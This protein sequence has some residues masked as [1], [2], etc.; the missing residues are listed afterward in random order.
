M[1]RRLA[2]ILAADVAAYSRLMHENEEATHVRFIEVLSGVVEPAIAQHGGR[3]VKSTGDG[4]LAEFGSAVDAVGCAMQF[5]D[6]IAAINADAAD[7]SPLEFRVGIHVGEVIVEHRDIYGD[8]VNIA[9][10]VNGVA[11]AGGITVSEAVHENVRG[12]L[13]CD[14]EDLGAQQVKNIARPLRLFRVLSARRRS[15]PAPRRPVAPARP[16]IAVLAFQNLS[17]DPE[18]DNFADGIVEDVATALSRFRALFV[19]ARKSTSTHQQRGVDARQVGRELGARYVVEGSLRKVGS[20]LRISVQAVQ[21]DTG[22]HLWAE[23]Y[24]RDLIDIFAA[25]DE[26]TASIVGALVPALERAEIERARRKPA[27][28]LDACDLYLRALAAHRDPTRKGNEEARALVRQALALDPHFVPALVLADASVASGV[29]NGWLPREALASALGHAR[30][31]VELAPEDAE[32]LAALA[33]RA[34]SVA[35]DAEQAVALAGRAIAANPLSASVWRRS[36]YAC[37]YA[38]RPEQALSMFERARQLGSDD[39]LTWSGSG[40]ALLCLERDGEAIEAARRAAGHNPASTDAGRI[41]AAGLALAGRGDEAAAAL[42]GLLDLDASCSIETVRRRFGMTGTG[43]ARLF[44]GLRRAGLAEASAAPVRSGG[45]AA[46]GNAGVAR[47]LREPRRTLLVSQ[48]DVPLREIAIGAAPLLVGRAADAGLVLSDHR[49]SRAHC[50]IV[51][52]DDQVTAT[53][54]NSTNGTLLDGRPITRTTVLRPGAVLEIGSCRL[55]YCC[56]AAADP[57]ATIAGSAPESLFGLTAAAGTC[58]LNGE[59]GSRAVM[60]YKGYISGRIDTW[61]W[62]TISPS[63]PSRVCLRPKE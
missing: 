31:A 4:F 34:A 39:D 56:E 60:E 22:A 52:A 3:I 25:Q 62:T 9:V 50:R 40:Y 63:A 59:R 29:A 47:A 5:Q 14:F 33:L 2:A 51:L 53:D 13:S 48:P 6:D 18:Q 42:R 20:R 38:G 55:E 26:T 27:H 30:L 17:G 8:G 57:D 28:D 37:L 7:E 43:G 44:E 21:T 46:T 12:R 49:V 54:L 19:I 11:D 23:R 58:W 45:A 41:L 1:T 61:A 15:E 32:A 36:G 16:S 10:R 35:L 24:D